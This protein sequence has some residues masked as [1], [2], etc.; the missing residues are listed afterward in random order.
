MPKLYQVILK[1]SYQ[2]QLIINAPTF[3][4]NNE[5]PATASAVGLARALGH[6]NTVPTAPQPNTFL[7]AY[8]AA[9]TT[10]FQ[11]EE[12]LV[13]NLYDVHDFYTAA[14]SG[15]GWKGDIAVTTNGAVSFM[16]SKLQTNRVR[17]DIGRG[18]M[19]LTPMTEENYA[20][21]GSLIGGTLALLQTVC[22]RLNE[23]P[24]FTEGADATDFI[25]CVISKEKRPVPNSNPVREAYYYYT[26]PAV[27]LEHVAVGVTWMVKDRVTSQVTR[28]IGKGA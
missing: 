18:S 27:Q 12:I 22:D 10:I 5:T 20:A 14:L 2:N 1:G 28:K 6:P 24:S 11:L 21:D 8:L 16:A 13:R 19:A 9:Q 15:T 17:Q 26:D 3:I 23:P 7:D 25:P 4:T